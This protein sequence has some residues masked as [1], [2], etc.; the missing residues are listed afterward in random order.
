MSGTCF[1]I[2]RSDPDMAKLAKSEWL[3]GPAAAPE[4]DPD[5]AAENYPEIEQN[6]GLV[7]IYGPWTSGSYAYA[8]HEQYD[9]EIAGLELFHGSQAPDPDAATETGATVEQHDGETMGLKPLCHQ[10]KPDPDATTEIRVKVEQHDDEIAGLEPLY[11]LRKP[12]PEAVIEVSALE[13]LHNSRAP[14]LNFVIENLTEAKQHG[15]D[16][17]EPER[18]YDLQTRDLDAYADTETDLAMRMIIKERFIHAER[19]ADEKIEWAERAKR[20]LSSHIKHLD[21]QLGKI[22]HREDDMAVIDGFGMPSGR[23][24]GRHSGD[25]NRKRKQSDSVLTSSTPLGIKRQRRTR[26]S[27]STPIPDLVTSPS[28]R[29]AWSPAPD[30]ELV[31][32]VR[33]QH[34]ESK[35][36]RESEKLYCICRQPS[37]GPMIFCEG[38]VSTARSTL[39]YFMKES[40]ARDR[41]A[42]TDGF[43]TTALR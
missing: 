25:A 6:N 21:E 3:Y 10:S 28:V 38:E 33:A 37:Y 19:L 16:H 31:N 35:E 9:C 15:D 5:A 14:V 27:S 30:N 23:R 36:P 13:L 24:A 22:E 26:R 8:K 4:T 11:D 18:P 41:A 39:F 32:V 1:E 12:D 29:T 34:K 40:H 43:I 2:E 42:S 20:L 7:W 17:S